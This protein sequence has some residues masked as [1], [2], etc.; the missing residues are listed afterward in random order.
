M[1]ERQLRTF[2][3]HWRWPSAAS[4]L[5]RAAPHARHA[6]RRFRSATRPAKRERAATVALL[7]AVVKRPSLLD[8]VRGRRMRAGWR[9]CAATGCRTR[10]PSFALAALDGLYFWSLLGLARVPGRA[11]RARCAACSRH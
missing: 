10:R 4:R 9:S 3:Q 5:G 8:P 11:L 1:V 6:A 7:A 2:D